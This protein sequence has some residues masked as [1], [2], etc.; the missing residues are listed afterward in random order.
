MDYMG[1]LEMVYAIIVGAGVLGA[2]IATLVKAT[3]LNEK[4]DK[5]QQPI[6]DGLEIA[7]EKAR[8]VKNI[9]ENTAD[10]LENLR[11]ALDDDPGNNPS[12]D[13]MKDSI[14][15]VIDLF[16]SSQDYESVIA[17]NTLKKSTYKLKSIGSMK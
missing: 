16:R 6:I 2:S 1:I 17:A 8:W 11:L 3:K 4:V 9:S 5:V 10:A 13:D 15:D 7:E 12:W 14:E